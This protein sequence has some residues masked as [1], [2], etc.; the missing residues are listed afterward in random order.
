MNSESEP[1]C[2]EAVRKRNVPSSNMKSNVRQEEKTSV[3]KPAK[4]M[5]KEKEENEEEAEKQKIEQIKQT[6]VTFLQ[7]YNECLDWD[8]LRLF[9]S[10]LFFFFSGVFVLSLL[11]LC[12]IYMFNER[13]WN[14]YFPT[15]KKD[16]L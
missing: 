2:C 6:K 5:E 8:M 7:F 10:V 4:Q 1:I 13:L 9:F 15:T 16:E 11:Y 12:F 3:T 14:V